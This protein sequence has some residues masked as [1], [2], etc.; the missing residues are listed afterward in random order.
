MMM[1]CYNKTVTKEYINTQMD[2]HKCY[3]LLTLFWYKSVI[4]LIRPN[5]CV[6]VNLD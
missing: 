4:I 5:C 3:T 2:F 1:I 6:E